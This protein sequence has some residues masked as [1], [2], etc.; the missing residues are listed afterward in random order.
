MEANPCRRFLRAIVVILF[1]RLASIIR[2]YIPTLDSWAVFES[3]VLMAILA[4]TSVQEEHAS[5]NRKNL[6][7]YSPG[8]DSFYRIGS[9]A[10]PST[11][12]SPLDFRQQLA[13]SRG[14]I[15]PG[16]R[17]GSLEGKAPAVPLWPAIVGA[18]G[19]LASD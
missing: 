18:Q 2:L 13:R 6:R 15:P 12:I 7:C 17:Q 19:L 3:C 1:E 16:R 4:S 5:T 10:R 11:S 9:G 8:P 14:R